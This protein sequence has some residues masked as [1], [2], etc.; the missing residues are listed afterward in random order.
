MP[1]KFSQFQAGTP[2]VDTDQVVGFNTDNKRWTA[3]Q[4]KAYIGQV[5]TSWDG[6]T[7]PVNAEGDRDWET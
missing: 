6:S 1:T 2:I 7:V 5:V 4:L 3:S